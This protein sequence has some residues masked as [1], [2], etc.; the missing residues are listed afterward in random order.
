M[1][2]RG[3]ATFRLAGGGIPHPPAGSS[4]NPGAAAAA[5]QEELGGWTPR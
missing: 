1:E 5:G 2:N 3:E 4:E